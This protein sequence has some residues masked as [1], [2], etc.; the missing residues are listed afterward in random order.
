[1]KKCSCVN[2]LGDNIPRDN[3]ENVAKKLPSF[4]GNNVVNVKSHI[5]YFMVCVNKTCVAN[6]YEDV[7][8]NLFVFSLEEY[9]SS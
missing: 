7:K 9:D 5:K 4:Q 3:G 6:D 2:R 1:V 8:M